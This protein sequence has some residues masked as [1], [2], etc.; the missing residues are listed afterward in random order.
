MVKKVL[1][2]GVSGLLGNTLMLSIVN[3]SKYKV[4]GTCRTQSNNK[5]YLKYKKNLIKNFS[6]NNL[7][8]IEKI[9]KKFK[10]DYLVNCIGITN[11]DVQKTTIFN[12]FFINF[13]LP[14]FLNS[15]SK[16]NNFKF[17]HISTD[18]VFNGKN[19]SYREDSF[20]SAVDLY[21]ISKSFGE[22]LS[23]HENTVILRTSIIGHEVNYKKG[24]LE[25]FLCQNKQVNGFYNA[26]YSGVTTNELS[27][28][29]IKL[30]KL[31]NING[32]YQISSKPIRKYDL[33][34]MIKKIYNRSIKIK[35]NLSINKK[36]ILNSSKF[37]NDT[38]IIINCWETQLTSMKLFYEKYQK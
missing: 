34:M 12:T 19:K 27:Q 13:Y 7:K 33:L 15:L 20:K 14:Q 2:L 8:K 1:I 25:W 32:L 37:K 35:K 9:V 38:K 6:I 5:F 3:N 4:L 17:F 30:F 22:E 29:V 10:P 23:M 11:K 24:L 21:G 31:G 26:I 16:K 36:L 28:I 18:C